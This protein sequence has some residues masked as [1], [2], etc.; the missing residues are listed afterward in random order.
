[1][2]TNSFFDINRLK[3]LLIR[4]LSINYKTFLIATVA[5]IGFM[6]LIGTKILLLDSKSLNVGDIFGIFL[7]AFFIGGFIFTSI[8]F[9]ELNSP[10]RGYLYLTLPA[11]AFEKLL[12]MWLI[13]SIFYVIF[14]GIIVYFINLYYVFIA[15]IFT[16]KS[17]EIINL[18]SLDVLE[19]FGMYLVFNSIFLLGAIYFRRINLFKTLLAGFVLIT[20]LSIYIGLLGKILFN[21][22]AVESHDLNRTFELKFTFENQIVPIAKFLFWFALAPFFLT[23]SYFRLKERQV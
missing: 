13:T 12:S 17:I 21:H 1:M 18:F 6:M 23:V 8:I 3:Y 9:S 19:A 5:V 11:S 16:S 22:F 10:H 14:G 4:Q 15:T 20:I 7:P 2:E